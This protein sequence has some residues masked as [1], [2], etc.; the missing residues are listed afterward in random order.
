MVFEGGKMR[1]I[2]IQQG[3]VLRTSRN[4]HRAANPVTGL[5][6]YSSIID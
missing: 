4:C 2:Q 1:G 5:H 3:L 6:E